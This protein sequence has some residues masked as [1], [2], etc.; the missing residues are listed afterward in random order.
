[1]FVI[2]SLFNRN[3]PVIHHLPLSLFVIITTF[4]CSALI[5]FVLIKY[6][7]ITGQAIEQLANGYELGLVRPIPNSIAAN[8]FETI[9]SA[10]AVTID[11]TR[12]VESS[13][14]ESTNSLNLAQTVTIDSNRE[15]PVLETLESANYVNTSQ[16]VRMPFHR[17]V[18]IIYII[19]A[20]VFLSFNAVVDTYI[21]V[22]N[23]SMPL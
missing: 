9:N 15:T 19:G 4:I 11:T 17:R 7:I 12:A 14:I 1:M 6:V 20:V 13:T 16:D 3:L 10:R 23:T 18:I 22:S 5:I 21:L 8:S 2:K